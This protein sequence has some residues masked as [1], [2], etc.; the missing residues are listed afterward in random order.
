[1]HK[2]SE[3]VYLLRLKECHCEIQSLQEQLKEAN[4]L[5]VQ[6]EEALEYELSACQCHNRTSKWCSLSQG[7]NKGQYF[8]RG[9]C[10]HQG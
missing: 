7:S 6:L 1:M 2:E 3:D 5:H 9:Q 4:R 8:C 10:P